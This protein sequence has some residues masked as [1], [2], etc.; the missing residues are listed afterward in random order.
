M[1]Y[2]EI[3]T[4]IFTLALNTHHRKKNKQYLIIFNQDES[5]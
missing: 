5:I 3:K 2:S 1:F 4:V